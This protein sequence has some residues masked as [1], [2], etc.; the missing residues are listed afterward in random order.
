MEET[1]ELIY[2]LKE[3]WGYHIINMLILI[4]F[5]LF[6]A[7]RSMKYVLEEE[8]KT[9][10]KEFFKAFGVLLLLYSMYV[11]YRAGYLIP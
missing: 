3:E 9:L 6:G 1:M 8:R 5:A 10:T 11:L 4:G 7:Y 2:L